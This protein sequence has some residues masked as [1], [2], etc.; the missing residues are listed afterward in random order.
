MNDKYEESRKKAREKYEEN[1]KS[2]RQ[3]INKRSSAKSFILELAN[4]EDLKNIE[5]YVK[6]RKKALEHKNKLD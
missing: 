5:D 1:N 4:E 6:R 3:Y 2:R